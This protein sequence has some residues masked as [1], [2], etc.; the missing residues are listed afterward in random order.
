M[1][2]AAPAQTPLG[3]LGSRARV[4]ARRGVTLVEIM[5]VLA[6]LVGLVALG[7]PAIGS[8]LG[9]RQH[10]AVRDLTL[11]YELLH[12]Q[13]QLNNVTFRVA[14]HL[15]ANKYVVEAGDAETLVFADPEARRR[16]EEER[17]DKLKRFSKEEAE[18]AEA[19]EQSKFA[20][21]SAMFRTEVELPPGT[22]FARIYTPQY[23]DWVEPGDL[24]ED[25]PDW[26]VYSYVFANGFSEH[27]VVQ[28]VDEDDP[29]EG[30]TIV[31]EPLSGQVR[32]LP[33]LVHWR[34]TLGSF[35]EAGPDLPA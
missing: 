3:S 28:I 30:Y 5:V 14:Y 27:T 1:L 8:I 4:R 7:A 25:D 15:G 2:R 26:V 35:P 23:G 31:V 24:D 20:R 21:V 6:L 33:E 16:Y 22:V 18:A 12:D 34:E 9:I 11:T 29:A 32:M 17:Q 10:A 19:E 13:A